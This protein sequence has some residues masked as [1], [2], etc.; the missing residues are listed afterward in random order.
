MK[1]WKPF[2]LPTLTTFQHS[3]EVNAKA[4]KKVNEMGIGKEVKLFLFANHMIL[5][6]ENPRGST[7]K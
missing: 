3:M 5:Y 6:I 7:Q 4:I 1:S 2:H